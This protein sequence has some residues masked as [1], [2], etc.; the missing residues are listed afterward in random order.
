MSSTG[1]FARAARGPRVRNASGGSRGGSNAIRRRRRPASC[2]RS[3]PSSAASQSVRAVG[4]ARSADGHRP[5]LW[6]RGRRT[7]MSPRR[8]S[9]RLHSSLHGP[10]AMIRAD[11]PRSDRARVHRH[12]GRLVPRPEPAQAGSRPQGGRRSAVRACSE[13][14]R[15]FRR[16]RHRDRSLRATSLGGAPDASARSG[17]RLRTCAVRSDIGAVA[18]PALRR[19]R[20]GRVH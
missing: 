14:T 19:F 10:A 18:G 1:R 9:R 15:W 13:S 12:R 11:L 17:G 16:G 3:P 8:S 20:S 7:G 4:S 5:G 2:R 6:A